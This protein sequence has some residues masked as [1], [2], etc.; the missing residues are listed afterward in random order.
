MLECII[1]YY[2]QILVMYQLLPDNVLLTKCLLT[3]K[4][5]KASFD[6]KF[7]PKK[8]SNIYMKYTNTAQQLKMHKRGHFKRYL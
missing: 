5:K 8:Y 6:H 7:K 3:N 1:K 4:Y 2:L